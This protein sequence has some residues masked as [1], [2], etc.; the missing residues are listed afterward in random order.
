MPITYDAGNN[1]I[2]VEY[3]VGDAKGASYTAPYTFE[4]VYDFCIAQALPVTKTDIKNYIFQQIIRIVGATTF[5]NDFGFV[6]SWSGIANAIRVFTTLSEP[7]I[8]FGVDKNLTTRHISIFRHNNA[9]VTYYFHNLTGKIEFYNVISRMVRW[10]NISGIVGFDAIIDNCIFDQCITIYSNRYA[11][12]TNCQYFNVPFTLLDEGTAVFDNNLIGSGA[13][14]YM[15]TSGTASISKVKFTGTGHFS[16]FLKLGSI[17]LS[18]SDTNPVLV[19]RVTSDAFWPNNADATLNQLCTFTAI[20]EQSDFNLKVYDQLN[21][22]LLNQDVAGDTYTGELTYRK[23]VWYSAGS[24][25]VVTL[26]EDTSYHPFRVEISKTGY[27]TETIPDISITTEDPLI[28]RV[29]LSRPELLISAVTITDCTKIGTYDGELEIT[30]EGGDGSYQY[31][32]DGVTYQAG[33]T[34][35]GLAPGN[36]TVYVRDGEGTVTDFDVTI[37]QPIPEAYAETVLSGDVQETTLSGDVIEKELIGE[38][39][40]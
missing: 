40:E 16:L 20:S 25:A 4:D 21:N 33:N 36:Y 35:T 11:K 19:V 37:S 5:F 22:L 9:S 15:N 18:V 39:T 10:D 12:I 28:V 38:L 24:S 32:I 26:T 1:R 14:Y 2:N 17:I 3:V 23:R 30:A 6:V 7:N 8:K 27:I 29:S 31:S 34:F 13:Q